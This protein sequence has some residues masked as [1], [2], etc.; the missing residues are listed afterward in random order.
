MS[1]LRRIAEAPV[2]EQETNITMLPQYRTMLF[3]DVWEDEESFKD[4]FADSPFDGC[5]SDTEG[6]PTEA[7][8][9]VPHDSLGRLYYLLYARYGN[10]PIANNDINQFKGK[11]FAIIFQY[12]P[13]WEKRLEIQERL[14]AISD[15]DLLKGAK[16]I[17]NTAMNPSTTPSTQALE[18]LNYINA[19]NTTNYK[20]SKMDAYGQLWQLLDNDVTGDFLNKFRICFKQFVRPEKPLL[21]ITDVGEGE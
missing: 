2:E 13:T 4:D 21:Y 3:T 9:I 14:R 15:A 18:E 10:N 16:A 5:I 1:N 11:V 19:Q 12:G 8:P 7:E 20:K 17:Y 6:T